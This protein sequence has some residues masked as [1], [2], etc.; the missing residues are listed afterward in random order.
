MFWKQRTG[1]KAFSSDP[2]SKPWVLIFI[3]P[4][5][6]N[7]LGLVW[8]V[9][10]PLWRIS[11]P[12]ASHTL[13]SAILGSGFC[14]NESLSVSR[15]ILLKRTWADPFHKVSETMAEQITLLQCIELYRICSR[16][17]VVCYK[18]VT[19]THHL[20]EFSWPTESQESPPGSQ[21]SQVHLLP[22]RLLM[23]YRQNS[24][25]L[26]S[27]FPSELIEVN[28][29]MGILETGMAAADKSQTE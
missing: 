15:K 1:Y 25:N 18:L 17:R 24:N 28:L 20:S 19:V 26:V 29:E 8:I 27:W 6:R 2:K 9:S 13:S 4:S 10:L 5:L 12:L 22:P 3:L 23:Y 21:K 14:V 11:E 16:T 7:F